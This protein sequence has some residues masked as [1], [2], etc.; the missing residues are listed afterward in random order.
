MN[1]KIIWDY[2][3]KQGFN[4]YGVAGILG[5]MHAES[6]CSPIN[7]QN[8]GNNRL[9]MSDREYTDAVDNGTYRN[10]VKDSHGYGLCQ[11]T[12][13]SRKEALFKLAQSK[14]CSIG[15]INVQL[16]YLIKEL[17]Q[18]GLLEKLKNA[19]SVYEATKIFMLEFEKPANQSESNVRV[20][21]GYSDVYYKRYGHK[22][23]SGEY[24]KKIV[25][26]VGYDEP[27]SVIAALSQVQHPF[28][29]DLWRK[30]YEAMK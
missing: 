21:V 22:L 19:A 6:A 11:W 10:F 12:Y 15:D 4:D 18:Y 20:R 2:L 26:K 9:N 1:E 29:T 23:S 8:S 3:K 30:L 28:I 25:T 16:E 17:R 24:I 14:G 5:N 27:N 7:L 13:W